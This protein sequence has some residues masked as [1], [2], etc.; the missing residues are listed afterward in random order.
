MAASPHFSPG[1]SPETLIELLRRRALEAPD[2]RAY[3][4][5][6]DGETAERPLTYGGLDRQARRIAA[7][8]QSLC[9]E[10][11]RALLLY[12]PGLDY[13]AAFFGCLYAGVIA[14]PAYPPRNDRA[15]P[16]LQAI[17][18]DAGATLVLSTE[19]ILSKMDSMFK[20]APELRLLKWMATDVLTEDGEKVWRDP[21]IHPEHL[22]F[23]QYTSGST[24]T[25][26]GV[27]LTHRN[28][29]HNEAA[30]YDRFG[31]ATDSVVVSWLPTYH[32]MGL[33][34]GML[35]PLYGGFPC[36]LM[37]P[38]SFIQ[39]PLRWLQAISRYRATTSGGP[40]FAYDHCV[41]NITPEQ[42]AELDLSRWA[43]AFNGAEPVRRETMDRFAAAFAPCGFRREAFYPCYGLA[44]ASL[45]VSGGRKGIVPP[46][47]YLEKGALEQNRIVPASEEAVS[48]I[49]CGETLDAQQIVI[50]HPESGR[51]RAAD[52]VGEIWVKGPSIAKG[53]W[54]RPR[55]TEE[56]FRA[57]LPDT[58]EGPFLRTG[59]LG[60]LREG[61]LFV[62]G[63][64]KDLIV[65]Q[66]RNHYPQDIE[67]T[68]ERSAALLR[69]GCGAAFSIEVDGE[70]RLV[71]VQEVDFRQKPDEKVLGAIRL[72]VAREHELELYAVVLIRPGTLP[73]TS[74]GKIQRRLCRTRFLANELENLTEW[75]AGAIPGMPVLKTAPE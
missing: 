28:L 33:I 72:A 55:E 46:T 60:F 24:G 27:M 15:L 41:R 13:V 31:H 4:F 19:A 56:T 48:F 26:K 8:L 50:A 75:H 10:G 57:F 35:Q 39:R 37:A 62:T 36:I 2:Q 45:I 38:A 63:R 64:L 3:T 70:E 20:R 44:E 68:V 58:G 49:G 30:I 40:N 67:L 17:I 22:A 23:L 52:E 66:G 73:K 32:D 59:D 29:L 12:P 14:V 61:V 42:K 53:Y 47:Q 54:N 7:L 51:R 1:S 34:G 69:A 25:P 5:L 21:A 9:H 43:L 6:L 65:I 71:V 18:Q 11:E 74:S 16:R